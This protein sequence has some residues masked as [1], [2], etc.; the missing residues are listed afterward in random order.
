MDWLHKRWT[1]DDTRARPL[2]LDLP[3][4]HADDVTDDLR[5]RL[6]RVEEELRRITDYPTEPKRGRL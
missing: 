4:D 3:H 6:K 1:H 2:K 5:L